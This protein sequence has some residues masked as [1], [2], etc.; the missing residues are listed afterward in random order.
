[1]AG[2]HYSAA[3]SFLTPNITTNSRPRKLPLLAYT[4]TPSKPVKYT[5]RR[6]SLRPKILK[7]PPTHPS[8]PQKPPEN[9]VVPITLPETLNEELPVAAEDDKVEELPVA[10]EDDKVEELPVA[11]EDDKVEE[12]QSSET[13]GSS[14]G[15]VGK[16]SDR[17]FLKFG[18]YVC[19]AFV[20]QTIYA[21][22]VLANQKDGD[23]DSSYSDESRV[24]LSRGEKA[25]S[26]NS[27]S[28]SSNLVS[29][30]EVRLDEKIEEIRTMAKQARKV[31]R[32]EKNGHKKSSGSKKNGFGEKLST[33]S[34][35]GIEKE[36]ETRLRKLENSLNSDKEKFTGA[37]ANFLINAEKKVEDG[38]RK[39]NLDERKENENQMYKKKLIFKSPSIDTRKNPKGFGDSQ[40]NKVSKGKKDGLS[41]KIIVENGSVRNEESESQVEEKDLTKNVGSNSE[42]GI[43]GGSGEK[44]ASKRERPINGVFQEGR[45]EETSA[46]IAKSRKSGMGSDETFV[47]ENCETVEGCDDDDLVSSRNGSS[48][49]KLTGKKRVSIKVPHPQSNSE[50]DMWWLGLPYVLVVLMHRGSDP[51]GPEGL[52]TLKSGLEAQ[53]PND[54]SYTVA[55]EDRGDANNFCYLLESFF[56]DLGD[57]RA[58]IV[59]LSI[60]ELQAA[61]NSN[62]LKVIV[63]KKGQLQL[64]A[65]QPFAEV[66]MA[67]RSLVK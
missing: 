44:K 45:R 53:N 55:F 5:R 56:E 21:V 24:S 15:S 66:E 6:N 51:E 31:E 58:D 34:M 49:R 22:W 64:Y 32:N 40:K 62:K 54:Y 3:F 1:M 26:L 8:L 43:S 7:I 20:L 42:K 4:P 59:P 25:L 60:K 33:K 19:S 30:E 23:L 38:L 36:I 29:L 65:G 37:Y 16:L 50:T 61:I 27:L 46:E 67:L 35:V 48:K 47:K 41:D 13:T 63:V 52:Y 39:T 12:L 18:V 11:A 14:N 2:T 9:P 10:A 57:V 17:Y 28:E